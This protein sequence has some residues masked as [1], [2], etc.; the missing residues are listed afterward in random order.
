MALLIDLALVALLA[1]AFSKASVLLGPRRKLVGQKGAPYETGMP[2]FGYA[3]ERMTASYYRFAV[4]FVVFDI[5]LALLLP[6]VLNRGRLTLAAME[7]VT[8]FLALIGLTLAYVW[9]KGAL[10]P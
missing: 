1:F 3:G 10:E 5:D 4:L 7:S 6:W 9:R 8:V 2:T